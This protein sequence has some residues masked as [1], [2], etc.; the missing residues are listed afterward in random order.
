MRVIAVGWADVVSENPGLKPTQL[1]KLAGRERGQVEHGRPAAERRPD[2]LTLAKRALGLLSLGLGL[3]AVVA[4][5][6]FAGAVGLDSGPEKVAAFGARELAAGA[7]LLSPVKPSPFLWTR[8]LGDG[9]DLYA[10]GSAL[11]KPNARKAVLAAAA[12]GVLAITVLDFVVAAEATH[13]DR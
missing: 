7:A 11:R 4:P 5:R 12:A 1:L 13:R 10:I 2:T 3:A 8:V 9:L 6:R